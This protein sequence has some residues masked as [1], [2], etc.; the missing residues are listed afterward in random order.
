MRWSQNC[1]YA[2]CA[3]ALRVATAVVEHRTGCSLHTPVVGRPP[4][5]W[6]RALCPRLPSCPPALAGLTLPGRAQR[7]MDD[8][9]G[10]PS[11]GGGGSAAGAGARTGGAAGTCASTDWACAQSVGGLADTLSSKLTGVRWQAARRPARVPLQAGVCVGRPSRSCQAKL[12]PPELA[13]GPSRR[14]LPRAAQRWALRAAWRWRPTAADRR[15]RRRPR[16]ARWRRSWASAR[17]T[18]RRPAPLPSAWQ[19]RGR[20]RPWR[21]ARATAWR[22]AWAPRSARWARPRTR[23]GPRGRAAR[24]GRAAR[25]PWARADA[26]R[27]AAAGLGAGAAAGARRG[28]CAS[29]RAQL[30]IERREA[31]PR[32]PAQRRQAGSQ[33]AITVARHAVGPAAWAPASPA[34]GAAAGA[35]G[36]GR[37]ARGRR[38]PARRARRGR[39]PGGRPAAAPRARAARAAPARARVRAP[40]GP[41]ARAAG[42]AGARGAARAPRAMLLGPAGGLRQAAA[43]CAAARPGA[44]LVGSWPMHACR[45]LASLEPHSE[46]LRSRGSNARSCM[47]AASNP[48]CSGAGAR[49][50]QQHEPKAAPRCCAVEA[51][52]SL[53]LW[54]AGGRRAQKR[55]HRACLEAAGQF[56]EGGRRGG[57]DD[58]VYK[59]RAPPAPPARAA[60]GSRSRP[61][62]RPGRAARPLLRPGLAA[63]PLPRPRTAAC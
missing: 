48:E 37:R 59:A 27:P 50:P 28:R 34:P 21:P 14:W 3:Q 23:R 16:A 2:A 15:W 33:C 49:Q 38:A 62:W 55:E 45:E 46:V 6:S 24:P 40:A 39:A 54:A 52:C 43:L 17:V 53:H 56:L 13:H 35:R 42:R 57:R 30:C 25:S 44:E 60:P 41:P 20:R 63:R 18:R 12:A 9:D 8:F 32:A 19:P 7:V 4:R 58:E 1:R 26:E 5:V 36:G 51:P 10:R 31:A 29:A 11:S 22:S 61:C 47:P